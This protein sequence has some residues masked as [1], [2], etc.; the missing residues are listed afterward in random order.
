[1]YWVGFAFFNFSVQQQI[2]FKKSIL[3]KFQFYLI[4]SLELQTETE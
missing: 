4:L 3:L 1:M 2:A